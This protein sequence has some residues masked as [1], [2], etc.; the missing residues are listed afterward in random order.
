MTT[1]IVANHIVPGLI[2]RTQ[3]GLVLQVISR[4]AQYKKTGAA[5]ELPAVVLDNGVQRDHHFPANQKYEVLDTM[6]VIPTR[7]YVQHPTWTRLFDLRTGA[8][9]VSAAVPRAGAVIISSSA[10]RGD[11]IEPEQ[12]VL[13]EPC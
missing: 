9:L 10:W 13:Y 3:T 7:V 12:D 8:W 2:L 11:E 5:L 4:A 1:R 6:P